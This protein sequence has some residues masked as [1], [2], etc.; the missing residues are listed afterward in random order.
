MPLLAAVARKPETE[1]VSALDRLVAAGLGISAGR[2]RRMRPICS[3]MPLVQDAAYGTLLR[4]PTPRRFT[5]ASLRHL[6]VGL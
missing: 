6:N 2:P 5:L 3:S 4:E 1:L